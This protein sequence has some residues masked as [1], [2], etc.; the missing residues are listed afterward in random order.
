MLNC[1][2]P[3]FYLPLHCITN[4]ILYISFSCISIK[5][6]FVYVPV[7]LRITNGTHNN[8][9][10]GYVEIFSN[11]TWMRVCDKYWN[12]DINANVVC[13]KL[14][15][16]KALS[17]VAT[18]NFSKGSVPLWQYSLKCNGYEQNLQK[19]GLEKHQCST[20]EAIVNCKGSFAYVCV[21]CACVCECVHVCV[22]VCICVCECV[23]VCI[24]V[25]ECVSVCICVCERV[26]VC[27]CVH[28]CV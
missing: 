2:L 23:S 27:E 21:S 11:N 26:H 18:F 28:M 4:Y 19:C 15:Y 24:C 10:E 6:V 13:K 22:S 20:N 9:N 8:T 1:I 25:C 5:Y 16:P 3:Y 12:N 17:D 14:G 7:D